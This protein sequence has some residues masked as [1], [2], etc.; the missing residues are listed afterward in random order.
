[1]FAA[2]RLRFFS[3]ELRPI[4]SRKNNWFGPLYA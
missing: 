4:D 2:A 3:E 1:M